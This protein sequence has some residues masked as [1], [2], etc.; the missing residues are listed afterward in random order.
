MME[1]D[2]RNAY[3]EKEAT[4]TQDS[5]GSSSSDSTSNDSKVESNI[6]ANCISC[7]QFII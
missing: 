7:F 3:L 5:N 4:L 6:N 2:D 1:S